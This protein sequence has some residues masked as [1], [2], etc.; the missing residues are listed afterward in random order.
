MNDLYTDLNTAG[1]LASFLHALSLTSLSVHASSA[2]PGKAHGN[3]LYAD[4][5]T[6]STLASFLH[7]LSLTSLPLHASLEAPGK[8]LSPDV[9]CTSDP[10]STRYS[11]VPQEGTLIQ[12]R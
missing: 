10:A 5:N 4:L 7:A 2:A 3:D 9:S 8:A 1:T 6:E 12:I 11:A